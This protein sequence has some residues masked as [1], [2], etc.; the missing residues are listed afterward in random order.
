[1]GLNI[2]VFSHF[3]QDICAKCNELNEENHQCTI[4][5]P[6][7]RKV[8]PPNLNSKY[9]PPE[10]ASYTTFPDL[11]ASRLRGHTETAIRPNEPNGTLAVPV[12]ERDT[13]GLVSSEAKEKKEDKDSLNT[14]DSVLPVLSPGGESAIEGVTSQ[15]IVSVNPI[16]QITKESV[17]SS[18]S[19]S[20][21]YSSDTS[22]QGHPPPEGSTV[23]RRPKTASSKRKRRKALSKFKKEDISTPSEVRAQPKRPPRS[24]S[25]QALKNRLTASY[26]NKEEGGKDH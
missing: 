25:L 21:D 2:Q 17:L 18:A 4:A 22:I 26:P 12:S 19:V 13:L 6:Q 3:Q 23:Q 7:T 20:D 24:E 5:I 15:A 1:M 16:P 11:T 14:E 9:S 8:F 10:I